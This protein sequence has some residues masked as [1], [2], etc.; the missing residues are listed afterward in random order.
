[1]QNAS[2]YVVMAV[3]MSYSIIKHYCM[4]VL[5]HSGPCTCRMRCTLTSRCVHSK[6][7][8]CPT[9]LMERKTTFFRKTVTR[10]TMTWNMM[11]TISKC[12]CL[13]GYHTAC[14]F[15]IHYLQHSFPC[16]KEGRAQWENIVENA[17]KCLY[18]CLQE[19][20][21]AYIS[22]QAEHASNNRIRNM[23]FSNRTRWNFN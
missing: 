9:L 11:M 7:A 10:K 12:Q 14:L 1:M 20:S 17:S 23:H 21:P 5:W 19:H 16:R 2:K 13:I 4:P 8:A 6:G 15:S 3:P 18:G 22:Q